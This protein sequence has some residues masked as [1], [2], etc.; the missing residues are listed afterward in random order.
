[1]KNI[2]LYD[3]ESYLKSRKNVIFK[4]SELKKFNKDARELNKNRDGDQT[5]YYFKK[6]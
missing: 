1:M 4:K 5:I 6:A 3:D 2:S